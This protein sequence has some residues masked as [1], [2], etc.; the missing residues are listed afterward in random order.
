MILIVGA[1]MSNASYDY[2]VISD[3]SQTL[4]DL[5]WNNIK[6][7][8]AINNLFSG[9]AQI[10]LHTPKE[11]I[12]SNVSEKMSVYLY[13]ISEF[14]SMKNMPL[15]G[16]G[17]KKPPLYLTL[18][19]LLIP[20][21]GDAQ[22]D[23][24][25]LGN[26]LQTFVDNPVLRGSNVQGSLAQAPETRVTLETLSL[27]DLNKLWTMFSTPSKVALAYSVSPV[28]I[29]PTVELGQIPVVEK[30]TVFSQKEDAGEA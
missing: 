11:M 5:L 3:V 26:I 19:Y 17:L 2:A 20:Y 8:A 30:T 22:S 1:E 29:Q 15:N 13:R 14:T 25:L 12:D 6:Y 7:D 16:S 4:I 18:H 24:I 28:V 23:Q 27:D 10:G 9:S 21:T